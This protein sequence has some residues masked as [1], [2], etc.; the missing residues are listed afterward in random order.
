MERAKRPPLPGAGAETG[1]LDRFSGDFLEA[2]V[3]CRL[4]RSFPGIAA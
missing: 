2:A 4:N 3:E 1:E